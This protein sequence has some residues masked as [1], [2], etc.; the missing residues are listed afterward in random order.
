MKFYAVEGNTQWL[1][2]GALFGNAPKALWK[3]WVEVDEENRIPLACRCLLLE[4]DKKELFLFEAGVGAFFDPKLRERYGVKEKEH[5][6]I[7]NLENLGVNHRDIRGVI[8]SHLHFDHAGGLLSAYEEG[9]QPNLLF[10]NARY[11]VG[12]EHWQRAQSPHRR[13]RASFIPELQKQLL[14][15]QR[16]VLIDGTTHPDLDFGV[17]FHFSNGHTVGMMMSEI[18]LSEGTSLLFVTDL[19]PG[20]PWMRLPI[21]MGYDRY[22][23][24]VVEEKSTLMEKFAPKGALLFFFHDP[25]TKAVRLF[26]D[27]N[28]QCGWEREEFF[29]IFSGKFSH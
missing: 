18:V 24:L 2:G 7:K 26:I 22:P 5:C 4:T 3:Q 28:G 13:E 14:E 21:T 9:K 15:S 10:P 25:R 8:L 1:D 27:Q 12:K 19:I 11:Y 6:L 20:E 16:L 29:R 23:E 17:S